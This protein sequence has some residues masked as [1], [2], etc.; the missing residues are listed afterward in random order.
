[1]KHACTIILLSLVPGLALAHQGVK[2]DF[3]SNLIHTLTNVDHLWP[4]AL[5]LIAL[6]VVLQLPRLVRFSQRRNFKD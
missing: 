6:V 3:L 2:P 1:M 4:W 5:M